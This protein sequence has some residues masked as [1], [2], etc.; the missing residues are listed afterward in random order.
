MKL[1]TAVIQPGRLEQVRERLKRAGFHGFT[2]SHAAGTS[3]VGRGAPTEIHRGH[4][5]TPALNAKMRLELAVRSTDVERA[6]DVIVKA[7]REGPAGG[8]GMI[9]VTPLETCIRVASG[10]RDDQAL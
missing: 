6:C 4:E 2:V 9:F 7:A 5:V 3:P 1:V 8:D 10:D